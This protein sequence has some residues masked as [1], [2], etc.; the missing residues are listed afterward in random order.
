MSLEPWSIPS[1]Y[2]GCGWE[3]D[4]ENDSELDELMAE[5]IY[6]KIKKALKKRKKIALLFKE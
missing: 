3:S 2:C 1:V 6:S 4:G 5:H